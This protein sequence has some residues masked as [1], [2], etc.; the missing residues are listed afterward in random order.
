MFKFFTMLR[1]G[2]A[3]VRPWQWVAA[4]ALYATGPIR[5]L[6]FTAGIP[7]LNI[8]ASCSIWEAIMNFCLDNYILLLGAGALILAA[9]NGVVR[10]D[11]VPRGVRQGS[12]AR[13]V[14]DNFL[15]LAV[16][17]AVFLLICVLI[18]VGLG[19]VKYNFPLDNIWNRDAAIMGNALYFPDAIRLHFSPLGACALY[20]GICWAFL[21]GLSLLCLLVNT[22][23]QYPAGAVPGVLLV[24]F[25]RFSSEASSIWHPLT[26]VRLDLLVSVGGGVVFNV[27]L[28][29]LL[30]LIL[31]A[32]CQL[33]MARADLVARSREGETAK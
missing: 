9:S 30:L 11:D 24:L 22:A 13:M 15:S 7:E 14:T 10:L 1:Q 3:R 23:F 27:V 31:F 33:V 29:V 25:M 19:S 17:N 8:K 18:F 16:V 32:A 20:M 26:H 6:S 21:C 28:W 4:L 2:I 5:E 12:R